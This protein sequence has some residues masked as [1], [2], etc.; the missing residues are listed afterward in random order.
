[1]SPVLM[2]STYSGRKKWIYITGLVVPH[3]P[4]QLLLQRRVEL[5][6]YHMIVYGVYRTP[7]AIR[8]ES[9]T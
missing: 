3:R 2:V 8:E 6:L 5:L 4:G 1:M 9:D 7:K